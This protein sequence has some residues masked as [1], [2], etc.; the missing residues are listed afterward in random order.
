MPESFA[1]LLG[2]EHR[3]CL[4]QLMQSCAEQWPWPGYGNHLNPEDVLAAEPALYH[5]G[6]AAELLDLAESYLGE[7]C[8][9]LGPVLK[10]EPADGKAEGTRQWHTDV[11]DDSIFRLLIYLSPVGP[12]DGGFE[13]VT[14]AETAELKRDHRYR[15]GYLPDAK[16][17]ELAPGIKSECCCGSS[18]TAIM[19]DG[20]K[21]L[22]RAGTPRRKE[23][24][25]L[26][27]TYV[28]RRPLQ[29]FGPSRLTRN[30]KAAL[31]STLSDRER[32]CIPPARWI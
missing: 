30:T 32:A 19:F 15:S 31:W 6:L 17:R 2:D 5:M 25:S 4:D 9:Y 20:A 8:L 22:H 10:R 26:T 16:L 27:F 24:R 7:P 28:T 12:H 21:V 23:R 13:F 3:K 29:I 11:E 18:G 14:M 1:P